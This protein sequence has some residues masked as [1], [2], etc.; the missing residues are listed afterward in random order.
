VAVA[1]PRARGVP[2]ERAKKRRARELIRSAAIAAAVAGALLALGLLD[3]DMGIDRWLDLRRDA[4]A[5]EARIAA[6][7]ARIA[8]R[9]AEAA[10]LRD[11]PVAIEAAIRKDLG[12]AR[13]GEWVVR[14]EADTN[15]RN[16]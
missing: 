1:K 9:E 13:P 2:S 8:A 16:P 3:R 14:E 7:R 10:A 11:D 6:A 12:L 15:L 4:A 5:A